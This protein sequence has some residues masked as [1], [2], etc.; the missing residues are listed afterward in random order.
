MVDACSDA[1]QVISM[2]D[3]VINDRKSKGD[4]SLVSDLRAFPLGPSTDED[5]LSTRL[6]A[7]QRLST[8]NNITTIN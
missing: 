8:T 2:D 3:Y 1:R 4:S 7:S 6:T 5:F